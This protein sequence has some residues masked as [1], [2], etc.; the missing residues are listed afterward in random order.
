MYIHIYIYIYTY[1]LSCIHVYMY[2]LYV[3]HESYFRNQL[4]LLGTRQYN[5]GGKVPRVCGGATA[6]PHTS[7]TL[8]P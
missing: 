5:N 1:V 6:P 4:G 8:A 2:H 3:Q 7:G